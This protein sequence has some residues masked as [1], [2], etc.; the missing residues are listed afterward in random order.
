VLGSRR[1]A[2]SAIRILP[3]TGRASSPFFGV[4]AFVIKFPLSSGRAW[5]LLIDLAS[6]RV[7]SVV[8]RLTA[9]KGEDVAE[10]ESALAKSR[11]YQMAQRDRNFLRE[12]PISGGGP[13][14]SDVFSF[15][16][17][18]EYFEV[19][20]D[21]YL[22]MRERDG[23]AYRVYITPRSRCLVAPEST[24]GDPTFPDPLQAKATPISSHL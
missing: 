22:A 23:T 14:R 6:S 5:N 16:V 1:S 19:S 13:Q 2:G 10:L 7:T 11:Q 12:S 20:Q 17:K 9:S 8:G 3:Q 18:G 21:A 4:V 24:V 15:V